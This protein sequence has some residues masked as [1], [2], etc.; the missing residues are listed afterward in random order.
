MNWN[1]LLFT[2]TWLFL[3][4]NHYS[5]LSFC[6]A[7]PQKPATQYTV[8]KP[9]FYE[10]NFGLKNGMQTRKKNTCAALSMTTTIIQCQFGI[11]ILTST[12]KCPVLLSFKTEEQQYSDYDI[13][14][15]NNAGTSVS[16]FKYRLTFRTKI[17]Q[18]VTTNEYEATSH[19][20][21]WDCWKQ[22]RGVAITVS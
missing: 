19:W 18:A 5:I 7:R 12:V 1:K 16:T 15:S 11:M 20:Y 3:K 22:E 4:W 10:Y 21:C 17:F 2:V 9:M 8:G 13:K 14:G 6:P